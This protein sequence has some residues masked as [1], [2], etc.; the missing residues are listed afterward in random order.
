MQKI[1]EYQLQI[2]SEFRA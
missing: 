2:T 1:L